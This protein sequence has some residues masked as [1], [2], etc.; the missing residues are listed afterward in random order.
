MPHIDGI[1]VYGVARNLSLAASV[2]WLGTHLFG[3]IRLCCI[4][5]A[6]AARSLCVCED[7]C[8]CQCVCTCGVSG[9]QA[10]FGV[11]GSHFKPSEDRKCAGPG[12][13]GGSIGPWDLLKASPLS[14][15]QLDLGL[16]L[17]DLCRETL[18]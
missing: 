4:D 17:T 2:G 3:Y 14:F 18:V 5:T 12:A 16:L 6:R 11:V 1:C 10:A 8:S 13:A 15:H 7:G 9:G